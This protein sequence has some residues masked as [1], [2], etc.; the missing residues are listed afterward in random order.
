[1]PPDAEPPRSG[2]L[3]PPPAAGTPGGELDR[4][5]EILRLLRS[6]EGCPW[7]REQTL[8]SLAPFVL[9]EA[10]ETVDAIE[11]GDAAA[12]RGEIGDLMFEGAFLAQLCAEVGDFTVADALRH[13]NEKLL[14]RHPHVFVPTSGERGTAV[15]SAGEVIE[16]WEQI[17]ARERAADRQSHAGTLDG[18]PRTLPAL[19]A[20]H[21]IGVRAAAVGFD[22]TT[23]GDVVTKIEEEISEVKHA[24]AAEPPA[25]IA[26]EMGDLLFAIANL[27]RKLGVE[28]EAALRAANRKFA[29]RFRALEQEVESA[30]HHPKE[31]SL[32]E[33]EAIWQRVKTR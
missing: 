24:V 23:A 20:A 10:Y 4:L 11:R 5:V 19:L 2:Q 17:K 13:V 29:D 9:E 16:Q 31:L 28:P 14:R 25:R 27:C 3:A 12:L 6:P 18:I 22:W 30:G 15:G 32:D 21:E 33:L 1:M 7:D 8:G 26:E